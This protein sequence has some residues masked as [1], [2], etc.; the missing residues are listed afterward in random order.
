MGVTQIKDVTD[1]QVEEEAD[2]EV[3]EVENTLMAEAMIIQVL[4]VNM[5]QAVDTQME[6]DT[7]EEDIV[8]VVDVI[9]VVAEKVVTKENCLSGN[10]GNLM[11][12]LS[13]NICAYF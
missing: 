3:E 10:T 2:I 8:E 13:S 1:P 9:Q 7:V 5:T 4:G 6:E 12:I 11:L